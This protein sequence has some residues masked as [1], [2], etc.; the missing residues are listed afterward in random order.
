MKLKSVKVNALLNVIRQCMTI[1]FPLITIPY[2]TRVIGVENYGK[3]NFGNSVI[4]YFT[5]IA[6]F[7]IS[8]YAVLEGSRLKK[9]ESELMQFSNEAFSVN[10]LTTVFSYMV[11]F[12]T[13][14]LIPQV[15]VYGFLL[16]IQALPIVFTALGI[17]WFNI[18]S[19]DFLYTTVR[20]IV[21][22]CLSLVMLF[23]FVK[24]ESD[25]LLYA[26]I[27]SGSNIG[28]KIVNLLYIRRKYIKIKFV[29]KM[30]FFK[31]LKRMSVFF[32]NSLAI[33]IYVNADLTLLTIFKGDVA[34]GIYSI[35]V[36]IYTII[37]QVLAAI[38]S[39]LIP[40]V[41]FYIGEQMMDEYAKLLTKAVHILV[42]MMLPA[43]IG[44][45]VFAKSIVYI[46]GGNDFI[47]GADSLRILSLAIFAGLLSS[48][49]ISAVLLPNKQEKYVL[50][51]TIFAAIFNI[52]AN[53]ILIPLYSYLGAAIT[54]LFAEI[55][56]LV[57]SYKKSVVFF[58][59]IISSID[60]KPCL[61]S[62]S[63]ILLICVVCNHVFI[64]DFIKLVVAI[65]ISGITYSLSLIFMRD[66]I[67]LDLFDKM[68][69]RIKNLSDERD[70][71]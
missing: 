21:V 48:L 22:Q 56:V 1:I 53:F 27:I 6:E 69:E 39:V 58:R 47:L 67:I 30:N 18:I 14:A 44:V 10:L 4:S 64:N 62:L 55:I 9:R 8:T 36:K 54:T 3:I 23:I 49:M 16:L 31:H 66:K 71:R 57:L 38:I 59:F 12:L 26:L 63:L 33:S 68:S 17:D 42:L 29:L 70:F 46:I 5:L 20:Y 35:S 34:T 15:R 61:F 65:L 45:F 37:K 40:R 25:Y 50:K 41:S 11:L 51:T 2:V 13:I 24:H 7:G 28:G 60:L 32:A 43:I 52:I 19:E